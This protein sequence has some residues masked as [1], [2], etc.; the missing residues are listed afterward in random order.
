MRERPVPFRSLEGEPRLRRP[1]EQ[2]WR[3]AAALLTA[4]Y[5]GYTEKQLAQVLFPRMSNALAATN[6]PILYMLSACCSALDFTSWAASTSNQWRIST[7]INDSW[8][9]IMY[10]FGHDT[11]HAAAGPGGWNGPDIL[12]VGNGGMTDA[13]D[14]THFGLWAV[15]A[16]P[17]VMGHDVSTQSA[18][19]KAILSN[20]DVIAVDQDSKGVQGTVVSDSGG[21]LVMRKPLANGDVAVTLTNKNSASA[22]ISTT[23]SALGIGGVASYSLKHLWSKGTSTA[24]GAISATVASHATVM[25]RVTP[26]GT[27]PPPPPSPIVDGGVYTISDS[28]QAIDDPGHSTTSGTQLIGWALNTGTNQQWTATA[29]SDG[30]W[31]LKNKYSSLCMDVSGGSATAGAAI[32][33]WTCTGGTNQRWKPFASDSGWALVSASSG[34]AVTEASAS[35]SALMTQQS[36][37]GAANQVWTFTKVE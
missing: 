9:R 26:N 15:V 2:Y 29:N 6:R 25:Y 37:T 35:N 10:N 23:A 27:V 24:T 11:G 16:A 14:R 18:A 34:M 13:E 8:S 22:T 3:P 5:P 19:T 17:L 36:N 4:D 28:G 31:Q 7:D 1:R 20:A 33:Q 12:E 32:I 21:L 30:T